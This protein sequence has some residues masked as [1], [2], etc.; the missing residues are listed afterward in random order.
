MSSIIAPS[1][2]PVTTAHD[3]GALPLNRN[4]AQM[5]PAT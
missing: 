2:A 5:V 4:C 1:M 3:V